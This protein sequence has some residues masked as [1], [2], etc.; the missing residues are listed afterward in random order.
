[1]NGAD[2]LVVSPD[3]SIFRRDASPEA[4]VRILRA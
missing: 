4:G 3:L 1:L 2:Q